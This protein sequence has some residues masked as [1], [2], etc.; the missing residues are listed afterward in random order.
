MMCIPPACLGSHADQFDTILSAEEPTRG[1]RL[2]F[3]L[4][5][6]AR[7]ANTIASK[8]SDTDMTAQVVE[9]KAEL[10]RMREQ[11]QNVL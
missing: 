10:E 6:L 9:L 2:E 1:R 3:V 5:E 8:A 11:V 7:E 4:Q